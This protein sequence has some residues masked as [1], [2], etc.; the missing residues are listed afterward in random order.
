MRRS[1]RKRGP[2]VAEKPR[3][4]R[5]R[6]EHIERGDGARRFLQ[7]R[8]FAQHFVAELHEKLVLQRLRALVRAE[9]FALHFL[10]LRRDEALAVRHGL[11][12]MPRRRARRRDSIS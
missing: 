7:R 4:L 3:R 12:A 5:E 6:A 9:D 10:Q 11:L 1:S 2:A 8:E